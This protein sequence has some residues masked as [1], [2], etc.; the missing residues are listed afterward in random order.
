VKTWES[1]SN[2]SASVTKQCD[3][4]LAK[5]QPCPVNWKVTIGLAHS[6]WWLL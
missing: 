2:L 4:E 1:C 5:G 6:V 3:L